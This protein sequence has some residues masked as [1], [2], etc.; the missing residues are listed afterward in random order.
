MDEIQRPAG[1]G[2]RFDQDRRTPLASRVERLRSVVYHNKL[3]TQGERVERVMRIA[4]GIAEKLGGAALVAHAVQAAQLAKADLVT[5][6][7]GEFPEL[8]GVIGGYYARA[9]GL[10]DEKPAAA[11]NKMV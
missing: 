9:Q 5:D 8:Q 11:E 6:M 2:L 3:G 7:V 1:I 10:P 4:R